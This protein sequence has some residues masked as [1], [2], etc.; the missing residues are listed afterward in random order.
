M[1]EI[2]RHLGNYGACLPTNR[3]RNGAKVGE[4][5]IAKRKQAEEVH[6]LGLFNDM[7]NMFAVLDIIY[8]TMELTYDKS[9]KPVDG[10]FREVNSV[11]ERLLGKSREQ[12]IGKSRKELFGNFFE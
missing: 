8:F 3:E 12:L 6:N 11:T 7:T 10:I 1:K 2:T 5:T 4:Q 9:G